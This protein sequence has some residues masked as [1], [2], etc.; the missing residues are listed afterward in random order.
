MNFGPK[1]QRY[2]LTFGSLLLVPAF[3]HSEIRFFLFLILIL[4][5]RQRFSLLQ[6]CLLLNLTLFLVL[7]RRL[8]PLILRCLPISYSLGAPLPYENS[9]ERPT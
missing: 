5:I 1:L 8:L 2:I 3:A 7:P 9:Y 4:S 6:I